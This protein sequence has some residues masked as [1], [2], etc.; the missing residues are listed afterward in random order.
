MSTKD[1]DGKFEL[2]LV[3]KDEEGPADFQS[4]DIASFTERRIRKDDR[5][6]GSDRRGMIRFEPGKKAD[7]RALQNRRQA[8]GAW[9]GYSL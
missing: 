8:D 9:S 6:Q 4:R 2:S 5:R 3:P 7:R 1:Q